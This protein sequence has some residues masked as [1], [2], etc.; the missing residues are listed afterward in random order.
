VK[1]KVSD[2]CP[3]CGLPLEICA[4]EALEKSEA[5]KIRVYETK[6]KFQKLVTVVEGLDES[7]L[8]K[9]AK[10]LKQ[11]LACGGTA[12]EGLIVLQGGHKEKVKDVHVSLGYPAENIDVV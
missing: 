3:R 1:N 5:K 8:Q 11:K 7:E 9:T 12:K 6:K 4:C 10:G 2:I